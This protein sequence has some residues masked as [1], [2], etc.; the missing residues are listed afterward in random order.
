MF[1]FFNVPLNGTDVLIVPAV[2]TESS[3]RLSTT[4]FF[5]RVKKQKKNSKDQ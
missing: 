5:K 4:G 1:N 2:D 3:K